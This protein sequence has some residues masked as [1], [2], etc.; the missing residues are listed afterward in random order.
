MA[1]TIQIHTRG[2][3]GVWVTADVP[4]GEI[5]DLRETLVDD[6]NNIA[7]EIQVGGVCPPN[8]EPPVPPV[9]HREPEK[10][11]AAPEES[12]TEKPEPKQD[13]E[14]APVPKSKKKPRQEATTDPQ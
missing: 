6:V 7:K 9:L 12:E 8:P 2:P 11:A 13:A 4:V 3:S 14:P 10:Q 5:L 1:E